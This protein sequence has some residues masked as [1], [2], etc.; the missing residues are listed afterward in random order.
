MHLQKILPY[1]RISQKCSYLLPPSP[2]ADRGLIIFFPRARPGGSY[3]VVFLKWVLYFFDPVHTVI[4]FLSHQR[5]PV[6]VTQ[7]L[8][9]F[10]FQPK[11]IVFGGNDI[12]IM[13]PHTFT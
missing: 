12:I 3:M 11:T 6:S 9:V 10:I 8:F 13:S 1:S 7:L 4:C 2:T 5:M